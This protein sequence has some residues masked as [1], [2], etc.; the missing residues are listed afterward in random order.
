MKT[1][2]SAF[3]MCKK[4]DHSVCYAMS[5]DTNPWFPHTIEELVV[6]IVERGGGG[7]V[8]VEFIWSLLLHLGYSRGTLNSTIDPIA[9]LARLP[10]LCLEH[11]TMCSSSWIQMCCCFFSWQASIELKVFVHSLALASGLK[12]QH[13]FSYSTLAATFNLSQLAVY[14]KE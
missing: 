5:R 1:S 4:G 7:G 14:L 2:R 12:Q 6:W 9:D 13:V 3:D 10:L 8:A 11:I